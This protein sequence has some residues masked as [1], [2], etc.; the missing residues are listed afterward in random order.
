MDERSLVLASSSPYRRA[1][2]LQ[3]MI[4]F[5]SVSPEID[6][7][8]KIG[9][10]V[11]TYVTRLAFEKARAAS[12]KA[13]GSV[14]IGADQAASLDGHPLSKPESVDNARLQLAA[15][16]GRT[17]VFWNGLCVWDDIE[18][19]AHEALVPVTVKFKT[20]S[21]TQIERYLEREPAIDCAGSLKSEGL[22]IALCDSIES[23]DPTALIGLPLITLTG[24]LEKVGIYAV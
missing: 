8:H 13:P 24:L 19:Q 6:E 15:L 20:L 3:L 17:I 1:L 10:K 11:E 7:A 23:T 9:E 5:I 22:G 4:P 16:S 18:K 14:I 12:V 2:L 21:A